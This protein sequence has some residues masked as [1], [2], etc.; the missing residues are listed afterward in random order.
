MRKRQREDQSAF[1][2]V[3]V[4]VSWNQTDI[5]SGC[6]RCAI[7]LKLSGSW[8]VYHRV[9]SAH[10]EISHEAATS[11]CRHSAYLMEGFE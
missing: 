2:V 5:G 7:P 4:S 6:I 10:L 11:G 1:A 3:E 9:L 8:M